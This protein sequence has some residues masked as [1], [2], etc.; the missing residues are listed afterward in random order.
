MAGA[1][2]QA[3][4]GMI[5]LQ[6]ELLLPE[7]NAAYAENVWLRDGTLDGY[8]T[9]KQLYTASNSTNILKAY[10]IPKGAKDRDRILDSY[11]IEFQNQNTSV[12]ESPVANDSYGRRYWAPDVLG[13]RYTTLA[14]VIASQTPFVLGI[15][16]PS[17]APG[18]SVAGGSGATVSRAYVYTWV[19]SMGE[20][21]P[22]SPPVVVN[23]FTNGTWNVTLTAP[24]TGDTT[25]RDLQKVRIYRTITSSAGVATYF[26]ITE[27]V[28]A[29]TTYADTLTDSVV[30]AN[31]QLQSTGWTA[32]PSD[33]QGMIS[34]PNGMVA[35]WRS[36]DLWFCE[37]YRPHA[38]PVA[39]TLSVESKILGLG[40]IGQSVVICTETGVYTATGVNPGSMSM[41]KI[42]GSE[43]CLS[44]SV[45][46][47]P[48]GV[49]Y[50]SQNGVI[51]ISAGG[52]GNVTAQLITPDKWQTQFTL[53]KLRLTRLGEALYAWGNIS[54]GAFDSGGF[55]TG[56]V[57]QGDYSGARTGF[58]ID[59]K[60]SRVAMSL[61]TSTTPTQNAWND[62]WTGEVLIMR[63]G[64]IYQVD[65]N[66][67]SARAV[68]KWRSKKFQLAVRRNLGAMKVYFTNPNS[69]FYL[70]PVENTSQNQSA[71]AA[72]QY[73]LV[74]IY[75]DDRLVYTRE[76]RASGQLFRL[77]S[78]FEVEFWQ[79][80]IEAR[81]QIKN[82]QWANTPK[83]LAGV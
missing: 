48:E 71:L 56:F 7:M 17:V 29:T 32:P 19:S 30:S 4:G 26:L 20:E 72:D 6:D 2:L 50:V 11:W 10:R 75:A 57:E 22:P 44:T 31:N 60:D 35:G 46:T 9:L 81:V 58:F 3:F 25:N 40:T 38:W 49:Y 68:F 12:I 39:Y 69:S 37:P 77:P 42:A 23:G 27:M 5:P 24:G 73:G 8:R 43:P 13:P 51:L 14:R 45:M 52:S 47:A 28:I 55:Y 41:S 54:Q 79:V 80:E 53:Q 64:V 34:M 21:G 33:L 16:A 65:F 83:E 78:G 70:N 36:N 82:V 76:L 59:T 15:P 63:G 74:R 66:N 18:L 62:P 1:K 61:L 67:T